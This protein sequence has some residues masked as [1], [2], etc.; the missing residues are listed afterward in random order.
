MFKRHAL[1]ITFILL[2][3]LQLCAI[4]GLPFM[5]FSQRNPEWMRNIFSLLFI[6]SSPAYV[7]LSYVKTL[8]IFIAASE[9]LRT[10]HALL[11]NKAGDKRIERYSAL[12]FP[13]VIS[14]LYMAY[15]SLHDAIRYG[16]KRS[17][18]EILTFV[19]CCSAVLYI[20]LYT[21]L[22]FKWLF[23]S[24]KWKR[25]KTTAIYLFAIWLALAILLTFVSRISKDSSVILFFVTLYSIFVVFLDYFVIHRLIPVA[26]E[27]P[28][29]KWFLSIG[30]S[31]VCLVITFLAIVLFST[32]LTIP[33][34]SYVVAPYGT[35]TGQLLVIE[36]WN[37]KFDYD[38]VE[39][40]FGL[41]KF[42]IRHHPKWKGRS[43]VYDIRD[44]S[45]TE[46]KW[47]VRVIDMLLITPMY[48]PSCHSLVTNAFSNTGPWKFNVYNEDGKLQYIFNSGLD[49]PVLIPTNDCKIFIFGENSKRIEDSFVNMLWDVNNNTASEPKELNKY[50]QWMYTMSW[51]NRPYENNILFR[52]NPKSNYDIGGVYSYNANADNVHEIYSAKSWGIIPDMASDKKSVGVC[53]NNDASREAHIDLG[54]KKHLSE[55]ISVTNNTVL[56]EFAHNE[57]CMNFS[58]QPV[59]NSALFFDYEG[60]IDSNIPKLSLKLYDWNGNVIKKLDV[61]NAGIVKSYGWLD[62]NTIYFVVQKTGG[63]VALSVFEPRDTLIVNIENGR[64]ENVSGIVRKFD[65]R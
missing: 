18:V 24:L 20:L 5:L 34:V 26:D 28:I 33:K 55:L 60:S 48:L 16:D 31:S 65:E 29:V 57:S 47:S 36:A 11:I 62:K 7:W 35:A 54:G 50:R 46:K 52:G 10:I 51:Q 25:I 2:C 9:I 42:I 59:T 44:N 32:L 30:K 22:F 3:L 4:Q 12:I 63:D 14:G 1:R 39:Y 23:R 38:P 19:F 45:L 8:F 15:T 61:K 17:D 40:F 49:V 13:V 41:D 43:F 53:L 27:A 56:K 21:G 58:L 6:L 37:H 64:A